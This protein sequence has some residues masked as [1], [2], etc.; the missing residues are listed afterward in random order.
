MFSHSASETSRAERLLSDGRWSDLTLTLHWDPTTTTT[1]RRYA[2]HRSIVA[3]RC[4]LV[5]MLLQHR[6][7]P[8]LELQLPM[9]LAAAVTPAD[10]DRFW[11]LCYADTEQQ[12]L[13]EAGQQLLTPDAQRHVLTLHR[14]AAYM[15]FERLVTAIERLL[16]GPN[17]QH[18]LALAQ[19]DSAAGAHYM[20]QLIQQCCAGSGGGER[21]E[22][23]VQLLAWTAAFLV[24]DRRSWQHFLRRD[25]QLPEDVLSAVAPL[26]PDCQVLRACQACLDAHMLLETAAVD[27]WSLLADRT[28]KD[29]PLALLYRGRLAHDRHSV[30]YQTLDASSGLQAVPLAHESLLGRDYPLLP[31]PSDPADTVYFRGPCPGCGLPSVPLH[32]SFV[33]ATRSVAATCR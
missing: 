28:K 7:Q 27:S 8:E 13:Q 17:L 23:L 29:R 26:R 14:L 20:A 2:V 6:D 15:Q 33:A 1:T 16:L 22:L 3:T 30:L 32:I 24:H 25:L 4:Q 31:L 11:A 21:Q 12:L 9:D 5:W 19:S 10:V 18:V